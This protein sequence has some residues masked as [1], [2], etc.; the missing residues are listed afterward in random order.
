MSKIIFFFLM[1]FVTSA[2]ADATDTEQKECVKTLKSYSKESWCISP[3]RKDCINS[4]DAEWCDDMVLQDAEHDALD[5]ELN[6]T[7]SAVMKSLDDSAR[8][9]LRESQRAWLQYI[10]LECKARNQVIHGG[11]SLMRSNA[12]SGC[13]NDFYKQRISELDRLFCQNTDGCL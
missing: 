4:H 9:S 5:K 12:M 10:P 11:D 13:I 1:L 8:T 6:K 7:Y 2:F 3:A